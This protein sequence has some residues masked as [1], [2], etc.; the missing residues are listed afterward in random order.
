LA[1]A[2][3]IAGILKTALFKICGYCKIW[4]PKFINP[5][6]LPKLANGLTASIAEPVVLNK[7]QEN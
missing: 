3:N 4:P 5:I 2:A 6:H 1:N 7:A